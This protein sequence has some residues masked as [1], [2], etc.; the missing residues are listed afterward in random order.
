MRGTTD[1]RCS[2][3]ADAAGAAVGG[4]SHGRVDAR[5]TVASASDPT[6]AA[7]DGI[8]HPRGTA[9]RPPVARRRERGTGVDFHSQQ[10][11]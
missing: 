8:S 2:R 9:R 11:E 7:S 3:W 6:S 5:S 1:S 10:P 4:S